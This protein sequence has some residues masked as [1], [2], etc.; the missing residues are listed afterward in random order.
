M[1]S[2]SVAQNWGGSQTRTFL[3]YHFRCPTR[4]R[5]GLGQCPHLMR[6]PKSGQNE[7]RQTPSSSD[8]ESHLGDA[9]A[10]DTPP[11]EMTTV[12]TC[13]SKQVRVT[14]SRAV[15]GA[16]KPTTSTNASHAGPRTS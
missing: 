7:K 16:W 1:Q 12:P 4:T 5:R 11:S 13:P 6:Q 3:R 14:S 15:A 9:D 10:P 8:P 2:A